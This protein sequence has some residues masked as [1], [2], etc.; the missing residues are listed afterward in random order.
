MTSGE[1]LFVGVGGPGGY[2]CVVGQTQGGAG[3]AGGGVAGG[4]GS[5]QSGGFGGGGASLVGSEAGSPSFS[6]PLVLAGGGGGASLTANG[7]DAGHGA[8]GA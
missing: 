8:A 1:Q 6:A 5:G 7:G 3:G 4:A 2:P